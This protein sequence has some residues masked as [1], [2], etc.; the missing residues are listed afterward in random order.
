MRLLLILVF[1]TGVCAAAEKST[2]TLPYTFKAGDTIR[3]TSINATLN[4]LLAKISKT[5]ATVDSLGK[6]T[7][8]L[9][10]SLVQAKNSL[11][12]P[13]GT[14]IASM[15][16]PADFKKQ[17][18]TD[19]DNWKLADS[20]TAN[21]EY[22]NLTGSANLPDLRGRFL[23]GMN[24]SID[25]SKGDPNG[26]MRA[27]GSYQA[28]TVKN[29]NHND[30]SFSL[31]LKVSG[32]NSTGSWASINTNPDLIQNRA[33]LPYGGAETRPRNVAVYW[34]IKVK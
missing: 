9:S 7:T 27:V 26:N 32:H 6:I 4:F 28:D 13:I 18:L 30:S 23:R 12:L 3:A 24:E 1:V 33:I 29:H 14:I 34:Y 19:A 25:S 22:F 10:D 8:K 2:D 31:L 21:S 20:S 16:K 15:L 17:F 5:Q 11:K